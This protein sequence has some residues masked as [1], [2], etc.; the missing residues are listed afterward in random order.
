[1]ATTAMRSSGAIIFCLA[2]SATAAQLPNVL[3]KDVVIIGGGASGSYAAVRLRDDY[4]KNIALVEMND[5]LVSKFH[6]TI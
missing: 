1:M 2:A 3:S 5:K 4:G 6:T